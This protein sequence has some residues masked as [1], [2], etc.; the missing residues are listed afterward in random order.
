VP[1]ASS[2]TFRFHSAIMFGLVLGVAIVAGCQSTGDPGSQSHASARFT[3]YSLLDIQRSV[4]RVFAERG[5]QMEKHAGEEWL[6]DRPGTTAEAI[7][8]GGL[9]GRGV[10]IRAKLKSRPVGPGEY[11]VECDVYYVD[12]KGENFFEEE[13]KLMFVKRKEYQ[14]MLEEARRRLAAAATQ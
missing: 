3:G 14:N 1:D 11:L 6:F 13:T 4:E 5:F 7:K 10:V 8:W 2:M 9:E 12:H